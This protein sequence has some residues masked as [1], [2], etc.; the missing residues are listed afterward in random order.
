VFHSSTKFGFSDGA[1]KAHMKGIDLDKPVEVER[2]KAGTRLDQY[3]DAR[4]QGNY[5]AEPGTDPNKLGIDPTNRQ[6]KTYEA[7]RDVDMLNSTAGDIPDWNG[8]GRTFKGGETQRFSTEKDA[9]K[10]IDLDD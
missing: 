2:V 5:Y 9:F 1:T 8:S 6:L 3:Q 7:Q 10:E 4:G